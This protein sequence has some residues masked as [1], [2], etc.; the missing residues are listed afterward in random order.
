LVLTGAPP[1]TPGPESAAPSEL[2]PTDILNGEIAQ[3]FVASLSP[4]ITDAGMKKAAGLAAAR[5]WDS[6][7]SAVS[8][9]A[10][11]TMAGHAL[12]G[13]SLFA[14]R[15]YVDS[16]ADLQAALDLDPKSAVTAFLLGWA[17][18]AA[19]NQAG[20]ITA[21]RAATVASPTLV[22]AYLALA[23]AYL[24]QS[25]Q[26]L[27]LQVLRAGLAALPKSVELQSKIAEVERR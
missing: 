13:M 20:A 22:P 12:R 3:R 11:H 23:D 26:A 18:S 15:Q 5:A 7:A 10:A 25:Q 6:V 4:Y 24:R 27:A 1:P 14:K 2:A 16:A 8:A 9:S 21:W 17:Q 19:G